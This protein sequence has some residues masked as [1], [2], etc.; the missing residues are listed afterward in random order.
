[1]I[2]GLCESRPCI[3]GR[4]TLLDTFEEGRLSGRLRI[5]SKVADPVERTT[6]HVA[7]LDERKIL[8]FLNT[9]LLYPIG[10]FMPGPGYAAFEAFVE[11][12]A[13]EALEL[14]IE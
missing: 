5:F 4:E 2:C 6:H 8:V 3:C 11:T 13:R 9:D 12:L 14:S 1:M 7:D 10:P